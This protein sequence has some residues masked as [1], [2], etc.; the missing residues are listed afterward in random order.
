MEDKFYKNGLR[1]ACKRCGE[2]CR[3]SDGIVKLSEADIEKMAD[4][5]QLSNEE[6]LHRYTHREY[7]CRVL[8]DFPNGDCIFY[9]ENI[10]CI[11][12]PA[13]P[14]QCRSFPFWKSNIA[15]ERLWNAAAAKCPGMNSGKL[16]TAE[17]IEKIASGELD[18]DCFER[19]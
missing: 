15:S 19:N 5:L 7:N 1:F 17:Q 14:I 2:C 10:G 3:I 6:F 12:Y 8:N 9:R 16:Y 13:R 18:D 11:I 4:F